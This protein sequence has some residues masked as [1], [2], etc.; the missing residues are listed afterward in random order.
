MH[1]AEFA[2][3]DF[4]NLE[5]SSGRQSV[6][7][8]D[9]LLPQDLAYATRGRHTQIWTGDVYRIIPILKHYRPDLDC[10][11]YDVEMKG[12]GIIV[13]LDPSSTVLRDQYARIEADLAAGRWSFDW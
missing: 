5:R 7:A 4:I 1:L 3:R 13:G 9:D 6:I 12:F 2:L 10:R 11:I 8:I